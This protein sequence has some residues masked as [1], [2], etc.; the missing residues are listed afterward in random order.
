M[1][2]KWFFRWPL[3]LMLVVMINMAVLSQAT[4]FLLFSLSDLGSWFL[5]QTPWWCQISSCNKVLNGYHLHPLRRHITHPRR[6]YG[7]RCCPCGM[8]WQ[9]VRSCLISAIAI[10][11]LYAAVIRRPCQS[12]TPMALL[13]YRMKSFHLHTEPPVI[14]GM[15]NNDD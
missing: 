6:L 10:F 9:C 3:M 7:H 12:L 2:W 14:N 15:L 13:Y 11:I 1:P 8:L 5:H 4:S